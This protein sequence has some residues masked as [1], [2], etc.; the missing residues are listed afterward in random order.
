ME[1]WMACN[2]RW[3][4]AC[5]NPPPNRATNAL[6]HRDAMPESSTDTNA[7]M[8]RHTMP[9]TST[10]RTTTQGGASVLSGSATQFLDIR[11]GEY[12][13]TET[14]S[15]GAVSASRVRGGGV[16]WLP[17]IPLVVVD[18]LSSLKRVH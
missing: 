4:T 10:D 17:H 15:C 14:P 1:N 2:P 8:Q 18:S 13:G 5:A 12:R 3:R 11:R 9:R 16:L 7:V 6:L